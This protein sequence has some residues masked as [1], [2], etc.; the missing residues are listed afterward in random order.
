[1]IRANIYDIFDTLWKDS[2][3]F[4]EFYVKYQG[5]G[6]P[7]ERS[8]YVSGKCVQ[9]DCGKCGGVCTIKKIMAKYQRLKAKEA[10]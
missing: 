10:A 9:G 1:M 8:D 4:G 3:N 2:A 7:L 5:V 6:T